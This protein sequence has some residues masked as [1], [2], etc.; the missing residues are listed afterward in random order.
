LPSL[1]RQA[2]RLA[3]TAFGARA[4]EGDVDDLR[5]A[6]LRALDT[7]REKTGRAV[8]VID[9]LDELDTSGEP[10]DFLPESLPAGVRVVMTCRPDL[11]LVQGL[12]ARL[13]RLTER[14]VLPVKE[15]ELRLVLERRM[16][17]D[18]LRR[19]DGVVD[20]HALFARL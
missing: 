3:G 8:V 6:L 17:V 7:L 9:A 2:A 12:R 20:W 16:P 19:L 1:I 15:D 5:N 10:L 4:Y 11:P 18:T 13:E 14:D